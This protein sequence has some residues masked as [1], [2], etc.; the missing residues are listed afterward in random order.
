MQT[1]WIEISGRRVGAGHP[2]LIIAEAGVNH[3]GDP[4]RAL[5]MIDRAAEAGADAVKFQSFFADEIVTRGAPKAGYQRGTTDARESQYEMLRSLELH[6]EQQAELARACERRGILFLSTPYDLRS[7]ALLERLDVA[8]YKIASTDTTNLPFLRAVAR[9]GRPILLST[10]MCDL[11]EVEAAVATV[12]AERENGL[13]LLHCTSEY[14]APVGESNL[15][16]IGSMARV[17]GLPVGFSD[18]TPGIEVAAWSVAAGA[19]IVEKHFT[20][21]RALPG[22]DH[23]ASLEPDE[24]AATVR[25][26]RLLE[27]ALG[28]GVK[29][30]MPSEAPNKPAMQKSI[31]ARR[32]IA[33]GETIAEEALTCKRPANGLAPALWDRVV[34]R[35][36][37]RA[38]EAD[39]TL[40]LDSVSFE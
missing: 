29:R 14:P 6:E 33:A 23:A 40:T 38:I 5:E 3:N 15:R 18:H 34:G 2:C 27:S 24:L 32:A 17:F 22:P 37:A 35:P 36:A 8:A 20:L 11:A 10:G 7:V 28:D 31:V 30:V 21:D 9:T 1:P 26:V 19:C 39:E 13:A 25:A 4:R 16:A 12:R